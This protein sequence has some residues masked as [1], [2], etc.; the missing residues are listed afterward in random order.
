MADTGLRR[1]EPALLRFLGAVERAGNRLPDAFWLFWILSGL[2]LVVSAL[3]A[4][5][6]AQAPGQSK[7]IVVRSLLSGE[8]LRSMVGDAVENFVSFPPLGLILVV[9]LGVALATETGLLHALLRASIV[10]VPAGWLTFALAFTGMTAHVLGDSAYVV[11]VPLGG[12]VFAVRGRNPL[13][14]VVVAFVSL[15]AGYDASPL[16]TPTDTLLAGLTT[17]AAHLIDPGYTVSPLANYFFALA[18][19][20]VLAGVIT[21]VTEKVLVRRA[22]AV[23]IDEEAA[24]TATAEAGEEIRLSPVE[25]RGLRWAG[26]AAGLVLLACVAALVPSGSPLRGKNGG[27]LDSPLLKDVAV[28]IF[29]LFFLAGLAYGLAV[30]KVRR[31]GDVPRLMAEGTKPLAPALVLFFSI[32]QFLAYFK[33]TNLGPYVAVKGAGFLHGGAIPAPV[34]LLGMMVVVTFINLVVTSGSAQWALIGP[35]FVPMFMVL[36]VSP[37]LTQAAYRIADSCTNAITPMSAYFVMTLGFMR[38]Y[39]RDVGIGTL[40]SMTLPVVAAMFAAWVAILMAWWGL[41]LPLGPGVPIR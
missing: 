11:L 27:I 7:T 34:L 22:D 5:A 33:W 40:T 10:R 30:G 19:S 35:I 21:L 36:G 4:G 29:V 37:E 32:S 38:Q 25:R 16:V 18:S 1:R 6:T 41:G 23:G 9:M 2:L 14:G 13:L 28:V 3:A 26:L 8:G 20:A 12:V 17:S 15:S 31:G 24:R 39:R